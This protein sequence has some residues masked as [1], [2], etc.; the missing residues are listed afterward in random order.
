VCR[1]TEIA[2]VSR[3]PDENA[4][5]RCDGCGEIWN[6]GRRSSR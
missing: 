4:Y 6:A 1:S 2:S 3:N 5:W